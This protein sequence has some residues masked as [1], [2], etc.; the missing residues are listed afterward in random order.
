MPLVI[1]AQSD[2]PKSESGQASACRERREHD[3]PHALATRL[4][5]GPTKALTLCKVRFNH[6]QQ[7][8]L[9]A[10]TA[11]R[12]RLSVHTIGFDTIV[13][14]RIWPGIAD[15]LLWTAGQ[16][17]AWQSL[18][19]RAWAPSSRERVGDRAR[20]RDLAGR[21]AEEDET[22]RPAQRLRPPSARDTRRWRCP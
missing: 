22:A 1:G 7:D 10:R 20:P 21:A 6:V 17:G 4:N 12:D 3:G 9:A 11:D 16:L 19:Q 14:R 2:P 15:F 18:D 5:H 8:D 13:A